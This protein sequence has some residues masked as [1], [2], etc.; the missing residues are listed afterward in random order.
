MCQ[1][2]VP[3]GE[4][5]DAATSKPAADAPRHLPSFV[6]LFPRQAA[7]MTRGAR[8]AVEQPITRKSLEVVV[9]E[10]SLR[11]NGERHDTN[12]PDRRGRTL[13]TINYGS[14]KSEPRHQSYERRS[15]RC[16]MLAAKRTFG[17]AHLEHAEIGEILHNR[18]PLLLW[19]LG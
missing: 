15:H 19:Q 2:P 1:K 6:E 7:R 8:D 12:V 17:G 13:T 16:G 14:S 11:G 3:R 4:I 9:G 10:P 5:D 18:L